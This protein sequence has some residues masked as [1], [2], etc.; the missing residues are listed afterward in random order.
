MKV[1]LGTIVVHGQPAA[2]VEHLQ[3]SSFPDEIHI[4]ACGFRQPLADHGNIRNL[5]SLMEMKKFQAIQIPFL[6][7]FID[8]VDHLGRIQTEHRLVA[9]R[10]LP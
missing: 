9:G 6:F 2:H 8:R 7:Q 1:S 3:R 5:G 4:D 10:F